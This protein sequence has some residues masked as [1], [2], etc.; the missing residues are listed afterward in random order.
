ML[1]IPVAAA[2]RVAYYTTGRTGV[3]GL[4]GWGCH[5]EYGS[6]GGDVLLTPPGD[7]FARPAVELTVRYGDTSGRFQVAGVIARVFPAHRAFLKMV[8]EEFTLPAMEFPSG[9]F[10]GDRLTYRSPEVVEYE[11]PPHGEGLGTYWHL[12]K[13]DQPIRGVAILTGDTPDLLLLQVERDA[14]KDVQCATGEDQLR[15][16]HELLG[17]VRIRA[18]GRQPRKVDQR[19][20]TSTACRAARFRRRSW[21][22]SPSGWTESPRCR[23]DR[24]TSGSLE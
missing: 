18:G 8:M 7:S 3:L 10:A 15:H 21:S 12:V 17:G 5:G 4:R 13:N 6:G 19:W 20:Q 1:P 2:A 9:P 22:Y 24:G 14:R 16:R 23:K 11:T